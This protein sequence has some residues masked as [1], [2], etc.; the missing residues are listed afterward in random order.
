[1]GLLCGEQSFVEL[2]PPTAGAEADGYTAYAG[3]AVQFAVEQDLGVQSP[4]VVCLPGADAIQY[5]VGGGIRGRVNG[6]HG[7]E[8]LDED[9]SVGERLLGQLVCLSYLA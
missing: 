1:M 5:S 7:D 3:S 2:E 6:T 8:G 4:F 9:A